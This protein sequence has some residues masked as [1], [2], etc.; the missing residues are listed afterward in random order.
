MLKAVLMPEDSCP[1]TH[2]YTYATLPLIRLLSYSITSYFLFSLYKPGLAALCAL[3]GLYSHFLFCIRLC[4]RQPVSAIFRDYPHKVLCPLLAVLFPGFLTLSL[5]ALWRFAQAAQ[6]TS[7]RNCEE[8]PALKLPCKENIPRKGEM[9]NEHVLTL[10][11]YV[12]CGGG[13][14]RT[15]V[16]VSDTV[17]IYAD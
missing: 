7:L 4:N 8:K 12:A 9:G 1:V 5:R 6:Y 10:P 16:L 14:Q 11:V 17:L 15:G 13:E 3:Q 2:Q